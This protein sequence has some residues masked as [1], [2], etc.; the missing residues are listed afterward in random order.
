MYRKLDSNLAQQNNIEFPVG[1][2]HIKNDPLKRRS[3]SGAEG[4]AIEL[5]EFMGVGF[6]FAH[7]PSISDI[8]GN[9]EWIN[10]F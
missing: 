7:P 5:I 6:G 1:I 4:S 8:Q 10:H 9:L 2:V 3:L